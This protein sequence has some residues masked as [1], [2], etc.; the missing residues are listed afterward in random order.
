M[1]YVLMLP[2][3]IHALP[4]AGKLPGR[5]ATVTAFGPP[6]QRA[7]LE[8]TARFVPLVVA[9]FEALLGCR[10]P[11]PALHLVR[12]AVSAGARAQHC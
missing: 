10:L 11:Y 9:V 3:Q 6:D 12:T 8:H 7:L 4:S 1:C 2:S 5:P